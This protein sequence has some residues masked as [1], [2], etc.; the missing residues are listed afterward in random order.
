MRK[1]SLFLALVLLFAALGLPVLAVTQASRVDNRSA[2]ASDGTCQVSLSVTLH[3]EQPVD[4]L[5]FPIPGDARD[6]TLGT[7]AARM[8][9]E[10]SFLEVE[11]GEMVAGDFSFT[12]FYTLPA[13]VSQNTVGQSVLTLPLLCG[14]RYGVEAMSFTVTLPG[15]VTEKPAFTSTYDQATI[16]QSLA[17]TVS[18]SQITGQVTKALNDRDSL[19]MTLVV[20]QEMFQLEEP[21]VITTQWTTLAMTIAAVVALVYWLVFLRCLPPRGQRTTTAPDGLTAGDLGPVLTAVG[22]DLTLMVLSW[23]QLGYILIHLDDNGRVILHKRMEMGNERSAYE[24]RIFRELFGRRRLI[25]GT[26]YHYAMLCRKVAGDKPRIHGLY[27]RRSGNPRLFRL[28]ASLVGLFG[29]LGIAIDLAGLSPLRVPIM[30]LGGGLGLVSAWCIQSGCRYWHLRRGRSFFL[31]LGCCLLWLL[32]GA[33]AGQSLNGLI[34]VLLELLAGFAGA[35]GGQRTELGMQMMSQVLGLRRYLKTS[36]R[37]D[38]RR[39]LGENPE[40]YYTLAPYA[41][42]LGVDNA[43]ARCFGSLRLTACPYMTSGMDGHMT[44]WEWSRFLRRAAQTLDQRQQMWLE[45]ILGK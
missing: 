20:P 29:G 24:N 6:V 7:G 26:G 41:L 36:S 1:F 43:F 15:D 27:R 10:G 17:V 12:I 4:D 16:E 9:R 30:V 25:D 2:V 33:A 34:V 38:L 39:I 45:R 44:A 22:T 23:A 8:T 37:D 19:S 40:Y 21:I 3:L 5:T 31:G 28:L 32:A 11:L 14:F 18:G 35:Y 13:V 42:A